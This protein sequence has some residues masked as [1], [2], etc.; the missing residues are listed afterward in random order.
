VSGRTFSKEEIISIGKV[1]TSC[2]GLSRNELGLTVC[3][4]FRGKVAI[5]II[6]LLFSGCATTSS[7][8]DHEGMFK[9]VV[10][11]NEGHKIALAEE[12]HYDKSNITWVQPNNK[13]NDCKLHFETPDGEKWWRKVYWDGEC[14]NGYANGL[15]R[16]IVIHND[17]GVIIM[18]LAMYGGSKA[19]PIYYMSD[20]YYA[21]NSVVSLIGHFNIISS[22][23]VA[24]NVLGNNELVK[25]SFEVEKNGTRHLIDISPKALDEKIL[26][27]SIVYKN[28]TRFVIRKNLSSQA[29]IEYIHVSQ[30]KMHGYSVRSVEYNDIGKQI[31][32]FEYEEGDAVFKSTSYL[33]EELSRPARD[34]YKMLLD[35]DRQ[36]ESNF[37]SAINYRKDALDKKIEYMERICPDSVSVDYIS[38]DQYKSICLSSK[39][40]V[41]INETLKRYQELNRDTQITYKERRA[42]H[43]EKLQLLIQKKEVQAARAKFVAANKKSN[44]NKVGTLQGIGFLLQSFADGLNGTSKASRY[45]PSIPTYN[46]NAYS[47][48]T[49]N[50]YTGSFGRKYQYDLSNPSDRVQYNADPAAKLRDRIDPGPFKGLEQNTGQ[51]GG[52]V[53]TNSNAPSW[54]WVK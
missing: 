26:T 40:D 12:G 14:K 36:N 23:G 34:Y 47:S 52:G 53:Y 18:H 4:L 48:N 10:Q 42:K 41:M 32:F 43:S 50:G 8:I 54:N 5:V 30:G 28:N 2:N 45:T 9:Y 1:V 27:S 39:V 13:S 44:S 21:D 49:S 46:S 19:K 11:A 38:S 31:T 20:T 17:K 22:Y 24:Y 15:G 6:V 29:D 16:E 37:R 7:T 33:Y 25:V 3:E 35:L 51:S